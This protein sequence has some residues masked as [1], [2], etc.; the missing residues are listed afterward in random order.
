MALAR[1]GAL[2]EE[3]DEMS[4]RRYLAQLLPEANLG[5]LPV[6]SGENDQYA[7]PGDV[8]VPRPQLVSVGA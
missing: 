7:E 2:A 5:G 4:L 1:L 6:A 3:G 8:P